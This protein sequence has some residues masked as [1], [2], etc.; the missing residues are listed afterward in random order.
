MSFFNK[1][2][3]GIN[4]RGRGNWKRGP[5]RPIF[6]FHFDDDPQE[7]KLLF[8]IGFLNWIGKGIVQP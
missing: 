6:S 5:R 1:G 3:H 2:S 8:K 4:N 7:L